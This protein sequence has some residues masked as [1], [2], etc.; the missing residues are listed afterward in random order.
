MLIWLS[1]PCMI[2]D[3]II[4][5]SG[6]AMRVTFDTNTLDRAV[7][8]ELFAGEPLEADYQKVHQAI[9]SGSIQGFICDTMITLEGVQRKDR[10]AVFGSTTVRQSITE[11][12]D[13]A[14]QHTIGL[15]LTVEQPKREALHPET[16]AR[17]KAALDLGF[18]VLGAP[19]IAAPRMEDPENAIYVLEPDEALLS[20]RLDRF[21]EAAT[22]IEARGLGAAR[23]LALAQQFA[24]R[25]NVT[26]P[27]YRSL[28][29]ASTP[30]EERAVQKAIAEWADGD[31]VAAHIGYG[32][33][34]FCTEDRG[35]S[36]GGP[37]IFN[38]VSRAWLTATYGLN[39][40]TLAELAARI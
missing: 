5:K 20:Q 16:L 27:S 7:R 9:R 2:K 34:V 19:R 10:T 31:S 25:A 21:M 29:R 26:E 30:Q 33:D 37:S 4:R 14:G 12:V 18:R 39:F 13:D 3:V 36:A 15:T 24:Q 28:G 40:L 1:F 6:A 35:R 11:G 38:D 32:F 22:A 23:G 17:I 8:P